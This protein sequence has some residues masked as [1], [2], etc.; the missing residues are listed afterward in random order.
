MGEVDKKEFITPRW[1]IDLRSKLLRRKD[2]K[3]GG[4]FLSVIISMM[5]SFYIAFAGFYYRFLSPIAMMWVLI[6]TW[7]L[8]FVTIYIFFWFFIITKDA[9]YDRFDII[10]MLCGS[11]GLELDRLIF[12]PN[13]FNYIFTSSNALRFNLW[14]ISFKYKSIHILN[15]L[16]IHCN[17]NSL[18]INCL[19]LLSWD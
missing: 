5:I 11:I 12:I 15:H 3:P 6:I 16:T 1:Y 18:I 4:F 13:Y 19:S 7:S 17:R 9:K 2:R 14:R 8:L 10:A